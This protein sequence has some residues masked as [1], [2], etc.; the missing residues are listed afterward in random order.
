MK[1]T[2]KNPSGRKMGKV[3]WNKEQKTQL[4]KTE[5]AQNTEH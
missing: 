4:L 5:N 1:A 3:E 2:S